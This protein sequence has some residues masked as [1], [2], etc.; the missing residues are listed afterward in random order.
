M[1]S[2]RGTCSCSLTKNFGSHVVHVPTV[3]RQALPVFRRINGAPIV[4]V[5]GENC[6]RTKNVLFVLKILLQ[7]TKD[8]NIGT[9]R[10]EWT[11]DRSEKKVQKNISLFA[12]KDINF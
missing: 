1:Y 3:S 8:A 12:K 2:L 7:V 4:V 5:S 11:R 10:T 6:A 9:K